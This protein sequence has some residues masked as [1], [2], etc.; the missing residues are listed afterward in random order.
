MTH[1]TPTFGHGQVLLPNQ[2]F[3]SWLRTQTTLFVSQIL[4][5]LTF[6]SFLASLIYYV[7][8]VADIGDRSALFRLAKINLFIDFAHIILIVI[9][10]IALI[11]VL[12][13]NVRGS[14]RVSLVYG[15]AFKG[16]LP[17]WQ[18]EVLLEQSKQRLRRFKA[19]FLCFWCVMLALYIAFAFKH[20]LTLPQESNT[21]PAA[22][23]AQ[24]HEGDPKQ[25]TPSLSAEKTDHRESVSSTQEPAHQ[26]SSAISLNQD[27]P[28]WLKDKLFPFLTFALNNLSL[29]FIFWCCA[30]LLAPTHS[31]N[32]RTRKRS[33][34]RV[35]SLT[36]RI[37]DFHRRYFWSNKS[38]RPYLLF[39]VAIGVFTVAYLPLFAIHNTATLRI[40]QAAFD[41]LS[42]VVNALVLALLIARLDSKLI[43]LPSW[44]IFVLYSYAAVQPLFVA[45]EQQSSVFKSIETAV[46]IVV[47]ISKIYFFLIIFYTLQTGRMLNYLYCF[48]FLNQ[49]VDGAQKRADDSAEKVSEKNGWRVMPAWLRP[50][51]IDRTT[52][53]GGALILGGLFSLL[54]FVV[55][56]VM[57]SPEISKPAT[58]ILLY[59]DATNLLIVGIMIILLRSML[60][61]CSITAKNLRDIYRTIFQESLLKPQ[62]AI[63]KSEGQVRRFKRYFLFFWCFMWLL[64]LPVAARHADIWPTQTD[65]DKQLAPT[66]IIT[67]VTPSFLEFALSTINLMCIFWCFVVLYL[68]AHDDKSDEKQKLVIRYS[69]FVVAL[70]LTAFLLLLCSL[71]QERMTAQ[72][73][74]I[75]K[76]V[77]NGISGTLSA[78]VLA[79]LIARL[80]SKIIRLSTWLIGLL[81]CYSAV[82]ALSVVFGLVEFQGIETVTLIVALLFKIC[83]FAIVIYALQTGRILTYLV[84]FPLLDKRVDSIFDNQFEIRTTR[85]ESDAFTFSIWKHN[86]LVYSTESTFPR[87]SD[88]DRSVEAVRNVM[89]D[90]HRYDPESSCGTFWVKVTD[91]HNNILCES[92]SLKSEAEAN[93]L[94]DE[95]VD[96]I[97]YCKYERV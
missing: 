7:H 95:S 64:Y 60:N 13:D 88:C 11:Q 72:N 26:A 40:F 51:N 15:R 81:F 22:A 90:E 8:D 29:M 3:F 61:D 17:K 89:K 46:L 9:F 19:Y 67:V 79:L 14:Y 24:N 23:Q 10:I 56:R 16:P 47:F 77:F 41:A 74:L 58:R 1:S 59:A 30:V 70:L 25:A 32:H 80:D 6:I 93:D 66:E 2:S 62:A 49:R 55:P 44:L 43:G 97:P 78:I 76:T 50:G 96:K 53:A 92:V 84:C 35:N 5:L 20:S 34:A 57:H 31:G 21:P 82:Q 83:F 75:H 33:F 91:T 45:F 12:D 27:T 48:P 37:R 63:E 52:F 36:I 18:H 28:G 38:R 71:G 54:A 87:K 68:P 4:A 65:L 69:R 85:N 39:S 86:K 73:L 94:I 42:G